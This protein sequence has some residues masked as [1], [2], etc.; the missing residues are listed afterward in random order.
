MIEAARSGAD[1][2]GSAAQSFLPRVLHPAHVGNPALVSILTDMAHVVGREG[3]IRQ[4]F[5][6]LHRPD[7]LN[8]LEQVHVPALVL[9]GSEDQVAPVT[10][11]QEMAQKLQNAELVVLP[12]SGHMV[13]LEQPNGTLAAVEQ[14]LQR[15]SQF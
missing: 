8:T 12:D 13:T 14:W 5:T 11:T 7:S 15:S 9:C 3:L 10:L 4:Q 6:A 1:I 2:F